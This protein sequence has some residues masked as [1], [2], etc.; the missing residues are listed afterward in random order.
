M[1]AAGRWSFWIDR[2]GT[3]TDAVARGPDGA[4]RIT[5]VASSDDAPVIAIRALLGLTDGAAIPPLDLRLGTTLATNALLE[6][7]GARTALVITRGFADLLALGDQT[8]RELFA[9]D[10]VQIVPV[11]EQVIELDARLDATGAVVAWP[12]PDELDALVDGLAA[13]GIESVAVAVIHAAAAPAR[14]QAIAARMRRRGHALRIVCSTEIASEPGLLAR[15]DTAVADAYVT[16]VIVRYLDRLA[17]AL[18]GSRIEVMKSSGG[19]VEAARFRGRDAVVSGP[20]GGAV[21][22]AVLVR[23]HGVAAAIGLDMGGT[24][25]DVTWIDRAASDAGL[26][27]G[28]E[29]VHECEVAGVRLK[30]PML[31]I[32]TVA[33]GGGSLCRWDGVRLT[34]GPASAGVD[35]GPLC[36][37]GAGATEP[38]I[39]DADL[40]LGRLVADRF[41][42]ALDL[43]AARAGLAALA[44]QVGFG[45]APDAAAACIAVADA[46]VADAIRRVSVA[47]GRDPRD[48]ALVAFGGAAAAHACAVARQLAIRRVIVPP[49]AGV[50]SAWGT[51]HAAATWHGEGDAGGVD[52]DAGWTRVTNL[53]AELV[54]RGT[55]E[56]GGGGLV[57]R[58]RVELRYAGAD[59]SVVV[60]IDEDARRTAVAFT[61]AHRAAFGYARDGTAV[62][63]AVVRVELERSAPS[64]EEPA[65]PAREP[66]EPVRHQ[67]LWTEGREVEAAVYLRD[68]LGVGQR[69]SGP[70]VIVDD[71]ATIVVDQ[72]WIAEVESD[73]AL[74]L[75]LGVG[76]GVGV[77]V[78]DQGTVL[79]T[80]TPTPTPTPDPASVEIWANRFM[81]IAEQMGECLRRTAVSVNIRE[82]R[83]FSCAI[84]DATGALVAN[85]P[86]IPVHL[87][88]MGE[89]IRSLLAERTIAPGV[90][91]ASNDPD[92]GGSHLP[93]ITVVTPAYDADGRL[94]FFTASRGHHADVGGITP[95]SMPPFS[96]TLAEEG[97]VIRHL[98]IIDGGR[99]DE[100]G[101]R[102]A[103]VGARRIDDNVADLVAQ[104]AANQ[105]GAR[106]LGAAIECA[107]GEVLASMRHVQ[108]QAAA[109]VGRAIAQLDPRP[110]RFADVLDDGTPIEV[111][112]RV[113]AGRLVIDFAGTGA[114]HPGNLNAPR[115]VTV[116]AVLYVLRCLVGAPIPL[117]AGCLAA[118][119]LVI[120]PRS[121]LDP[122]PGRAVCGGNVET[123]QRIVDVL[124]GALGVAAASQG[125]MNNLTLGDD[126]RAY[127][128]TIAGGAGATARAS[129]ASAVH[130]HMTNTR[131]TDPEV[132]EAR[133]PIRVRRHAIR[134]GSGGAGQHRGGDGV[135]RELE[136]LAPMQVSI[137]SER[138]VTAPFGL[139]G[140]APG[141]RGTNLI[142]GTDVGGRAAVAAPAGTVVQIATPGG[143]GWAPP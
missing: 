24:S 95:G 72:S 127:Y 78:G 97:C 22:L 84:F 17:A 5:K 2:G 92:A 39:S 134:R 48:A 103:L 64:I 85:A 6:R 74:V 140:G 87:G 50:L 43:A 100:A 41:P 25:T 121:L 122:G 12:E 136:L 28:V 49:H 53:A 59:A 66:A 101:V 138:R 29:R 110:R 62:E 56:L 47:R 42:L 63:V 67:P 9:L 21:A 117:N 8:R 96:R 71:T 124:L 52:L 11:V 14:E 54:A 89:T 105:L 58:A 40:V 76:V 46:A 19:L 129:G 31:A 111:S 94:V 82:R 34:V 115:A 1:T 18:P 106:L 120:P 65:W 23:R 35:P 118:V 44:A 112:I 109:L 13:H 114:V 108:D 102:A 16:P 33:A 133:F 30:A 61:A 69:I 80:P 113:T 15:T 20:A 57:V 3:F 90:V 45:D 132:L 91:Y 142:G 70:A 73:G 128:E 81:S 130:T 141:A 123:S 139:D 131:I 77:G 88:A 37:G 4:L 10:I 143:G 104:V 137:L 26:L 99:F 75:V 51:G 107:S 55:A 83:D 119:D 38:A 60:P 7:R 135:I 68:Q 32:H 126:A 98:A 93:D 125:T 86:H 116:A 79:G 36:Y 27:G